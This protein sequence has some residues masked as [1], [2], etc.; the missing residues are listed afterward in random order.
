MITM[1]TIIGISAFLIGIGMGYWFADFT[2]IRDLV[3]QKAQLKA[4][5]EALKT[6][7]D[8]YENKDKKELE[9]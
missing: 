7:V 9:Q 1:T 2:K 5:C 4:K 6:L 8:Y 3:N